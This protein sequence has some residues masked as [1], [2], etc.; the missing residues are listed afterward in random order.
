M[1]KRAV[2]MPCTM[3]L[4]LNLKPLRYSTTGMAVPESTCEQVSDNTKTEKR[5]SPRGE[6]ISQR[7][8]STAEIAASTMAGTPI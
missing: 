3:M 7:T 6:R 5:A 2:T 8:S 1:K 4:V